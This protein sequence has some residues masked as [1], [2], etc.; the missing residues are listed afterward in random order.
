MPP[1]TM[2]F[3]DKIERAFLWSA[4]DTTTGAKCKVNWELVCRPKK[5]GEKKNTPAEALGLAGKVCAAA[6]PRRPS[7]SRCASAS[8]GIGKKGYSHLLC[9]P[10]AKKR[11]STSPAYRAAARS[12]AEEKGT[13]SA[14]LDGDAPTLG[15]TRRRQEVQGAPPH[16]LL[17]RWPSGLVWWWEGDAG[18]GGALARLRRRRQLGERGE[19]GSAPRRR[20]RDGSRG[21]LGRVATFLPTRKERAPWIEMGG[22]ETV[23][24][25]CV[26]ACQGRGR[27]RP[28]RRAMGGA[29]LTPGRAGGRAA[30]RAR[31]QR[32]R[33]VP[34]RR[35]RV[36]GAL[37]RV[38]RRVG[39]DSYTP[40][41]PT[42]PVRADGDT[43][44][45]WTK[46]KRDHAPVEMS[47]TL[48]NRKWQTA[49]KK[50]HILRISNLAAKLKPMDADLELKPALLVHLVMASLPQQF[51]N[52]VTNYN[53]SPEKWDIEKTIAMCVQEE[54]RLKAQNGGTINYVKNNKKRP[55][56]PSN[57]GSPSKPYAKA[58]MQHHQKFQHRQLPVN[59][60]QC[61]HCQKTGHYKKD[62]PDWLKEL[63]AK[64]GDWNSRPILDAGRTSAEWGS[65]KAQ[66][67]P[68]GYGAQYDE[69]FHPTIGIVD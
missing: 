45:A 23:A 16:A 33:S 2:K 1:G 62:C 13:A 3:I 31:W 58:P 40:I 49:N 30:L 34:V 39:R 29:S 25:S 6:R 32:R 28:P 47:Y 44:D 12:P 35:G 61:L 5:Y 66:P 15:C 7:R 65:W 43:D 36:G 38:A 4:K 41:K 17:R 24:A 55:F 69:L 63:M 68:Y 20:Q 56:T 11:K 59:K 14:P 21:G 51:D 48:E 9:R 57:N 26:K 8:R 54:D 67:Y 52:F 19:K 27:A 53:M 42:D 37:L 50:E 64:K 18:A 60:D 10:G 22:W 46:K